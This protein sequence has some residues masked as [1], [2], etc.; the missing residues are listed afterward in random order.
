MAGWVHDFSAPSTSDSENMLQTTDVRLVPMA[1]P[2][3]KTSYCRLI[4]SS[5]QRLWD[6]LVKLASSLRTLVS[7]DSLV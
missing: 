4:A 2:P 6:I 7:Q 5:S 1:T 3:K